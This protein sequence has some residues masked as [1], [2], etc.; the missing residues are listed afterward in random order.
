MKILVSHLSETVPLSC[1]AMICTRTVLG[2]PANC[3]M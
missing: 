3:Y 1:V 2:I